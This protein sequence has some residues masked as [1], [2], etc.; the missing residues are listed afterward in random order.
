MLS[1]KTL[2]YW[3][4]IESSQR[5]WALNSVWLLADK[6]HVSADNVLMG[7]GGGEM[8]NSGARKK[9]HSSLSQQIWLQMYTPRK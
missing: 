8:L 7:A 6:D 1:C 3:V 2:A 5:R 4:E 9:D